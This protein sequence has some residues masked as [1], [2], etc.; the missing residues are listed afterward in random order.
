M[1]AAVEATK[2]TRKSALEESS[3]E[4]NIY[5]PMR[6]RLRGVVVVVVGVHV[7]Q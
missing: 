6:L 1:Y 4:E 2:C 3:V 7:V 5:W